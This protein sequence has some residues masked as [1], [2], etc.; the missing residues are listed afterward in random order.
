MARSSS[1]LSTTRAKIMPMTTIHANW[2]PVNETL[3]SPSSKAAR[4]THSRQSVLATATISW[5]MSE[6]SCWGASARQCPI[7]LAACTLTSSRWDRCSPGNNWGY[8]VCDGSRQGIAGSQ[9]RDVLVR[10]RTNNLRPAL[11]PKSVGRRFCARLPVAT[12]RCGREPGENAAANAH[13]WRL[14]ST[15]HCGG[16][17]RRLRREGDPGGAHAA[18][19]PRLWP[20]W[21]PHRTMTLV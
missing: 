3:I 6:P 21:S 13:W 14:P 18:V 15:I 7:R 1:K 9:V 16:P 17:S 19:P 10:F 5:G 11:E 12:A 4:T 8:G 2:L 20:I